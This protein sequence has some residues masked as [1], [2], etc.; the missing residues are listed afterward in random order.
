M[1]FLK[2]TAQFPISS[3]IIFLILTIVS[4]IIFVWP[5]LNFQDTLAQGDHGRDLYAFEVV[6]KHQLPY[7]DFWWVY[8]PIMP[9]YYGL[10]YKIFGVHITSIL[11]GRALLLLGCAAFFYLSC[12]VIM[13]PSLAFL[14]AVWFIQYRQEFICTYNHIGGTLASLVIIYAILSYIRFGLLRYLW[15]SLI[16]AFLLMLIKVNFGV[17]SI[18]GILISMFVTDI[19]KHYAWENKKQK[20]F[21]AAFIALPLSTLAIYW[22]LL[23]SLPSYVIRQCMP[24]LGDDQPYH[25]SSLLGTLHSYF[26]GYWYTFNS[27]PENI[28][29][30][31]VLHLSTLTAVYLLLAAKLTKDDAKNIWLSL[32]IVGMFFVLYFHEFLLSNVWY[33][34][35]W[36]FP[37][38]VLLHFIILS[39]VFKVLH[40]VLRILILIFLWKVMIFGGL[41]HIN[42]IQSQK[43]PDHYL[44]MSRGQIYVGNEPQWVDTVKKTTDYL[45]T[46]LPPDGLFFALPYDCLYYYLTGKVSPTRQLIFFD[47]LKIPF[48]QE[49]S[50]IKD[51]ERQNVNYVLMSTRVV[52]LEMDLGI[53]GRTY[54]PL[55]A[56]YLGDN[57]AQIYQQGGDLQR[58]PGWADNHG[59]FILKRK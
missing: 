37:F 18:F 3:K 54:C 57:F 36:S 1:S 19:V 46:N 42:R 49:V 4:T 34:S 8:G 40:P 30:G 48:E 5:E 56:K 31:L 10:F 33:R 17:V 52:S 53:L 24:Y 28:C 50:V 12:A 44:S 47:H 23:R 13:S 22:Y 9:Y 35:F 25:A 55:L 6:L 39:T 27:S 26:H 15:I 16:A 29:I 2:S 59:V 38:L 41:T 7:R 32:G 51:L 21:L 14:G 20:F 11:L 58:N 43:T 45:N